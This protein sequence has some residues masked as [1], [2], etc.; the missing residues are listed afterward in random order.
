[1]LILPKC[2][3]F[4]FNCWFMHEKQRKRIDNE[5]KTI[6]K[7]EKERLQQMCKYEIQTHFLLVFIRFLSLSRSV[8][9]R[10]SRP[11]TLKSMAQWIW[12]IVI[13]RCRMSSVIWF[14]SKM[15]W[16]ISHISTIVNR[17]PSH[18]VANKGLTH[19]KVW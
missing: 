10:R 5:K 16:N 1:M 6:T 13:Y 7:R 15:V 17:I 14:C 18:F 3:S 12:S 11:I 9:V 4:A 8:F 19:E 2:Y